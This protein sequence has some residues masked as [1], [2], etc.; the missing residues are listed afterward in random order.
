M[1]IL[2]TGA[3]GYI[4]S[5]CTE[6]L[7]ARGHTVIA[8]D[9]LSEGHREALH[10]QARFY[11]VNL[12]DHAALNSIFSENQI[13][14]VM[15]FAALCLVEQ[16]V[17]EPGTY[18]RANV[19]TGINLLDAMIRH[20]VK[21]FI[22]SSTAATYGEPKE[23]PISEGH[24]TNPINPYG[25]SK[26]LFERVLQEFKENSGLEYVVMRYFN[27]AGA[28]ENRGEDHHPE[29]HILPILFEV[30][31]GPRE[32]F[33][34]YGTDYPTPDGTCIRDY[35]HVIDIAESHVLALE[36][37]SEVAG[38]V[39]NVGNSRGFSVREVIGAVERII[40]RKIPVREAPRRPG[41]PAEL[42]ASSSR[43]RRELGWSPRY[44]DLDSIIKTAWAWKQRYPMGYSTRNK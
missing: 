43:I 41:D 19:A 6:V 5:V 21:R 14:A 30:A 44:S 33:H 12:H 35:V 25:S 34:I 18:Y 8:L 26:L 4:G 42:V 22:F 1:R 38:R 23:I 7:I 15:H 3:A 37:I 39:F 10:P 27:A 40:G 16:S 28:S 17:K 2:V 31:L 11:Q 36:K 20:G 9:D 32:A 13:D 29:T 24:P